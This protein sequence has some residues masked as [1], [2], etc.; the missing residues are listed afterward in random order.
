MEIVSK[1]KISSDIITLIEHLG[2]YLMKFLKWL[3]KHLFI[4]IIATVVTIFMGYLAIRWI[5]YNDTYLYRYLFQDSNGKFAWT[6]FTAIIAIITL[7]INAWDNRRKFRADLVS[8]S[9][10]EW[11][12]T[13]RP[14][15]SEYYENFNKYIFEYAQFMDAENGSEEKKKC[16]DVLSARMHK[17]KKSYYNIKLY[18]PRGES[19]KK[20]LKN[21]NLTWD[22]LSYVG[23][24]FEH[25]FRVGKI[26]RKEIVQQNYSKIVIKYVSDLSKD[27]I[28]DASIYFKNEWEKAK[29]GK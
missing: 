1:I 17:I 20:L 21:I 13:V 12:N 19:N 29:K 11:M 2:V 25:G 3:W 10:I 8:K 23:P 9:R 4:I 24:Y 27:G 18:V 5:R 6:G 16:N 26:R 7:A 22:E 15:I 28:E 14:Y